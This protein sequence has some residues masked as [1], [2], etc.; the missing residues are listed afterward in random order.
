MITRKD[1]HDLGFN[2]KYVGFELLYDAI[3]LAT[4]EPKIKIVEIYKQLCENHKEYEGVWTRVERNI[5]TCIQLSDSKY[6][7][8][9]SGEV[10]YELATVYKE[11]YDEKN[12]KIQFHKVSYEQF[13]KDLLDCNIKITSE[14]EIR[15][16]YDNIK[17]PKRATLSSAGYDFYAPF[18]MVFYNNESLK[19]PSG[20]RC[21]M[22]DNVVLMLYPRSG[23][24]FK[25]RMA[26]DNATGVIDADY[27]HAKNEGHIHAK[28]HY[29]ND[30]IEKLEIKQGEAYMQGIFV[31]YFKTV[32]DDTQEVRVGGF[33]STT[34][35]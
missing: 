5:R 18:D 35:K 1:L 23:L 17:L 15:N 21:E 6:K 22:N 20:I 26:L 19:F 31:Q 2:T 25:H 30:N 16:I 24:G 11:N 28:M 8:N 9:K 10:I 33:G 14:K 32:D 7:F 27:F 13:K 4:Y 12:G 3:K 29:D 34:K